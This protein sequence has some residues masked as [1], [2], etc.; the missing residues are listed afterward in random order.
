ML[1]KQPC[2][3]PRIEDKNILAANLNSPTIHLYEV[4]YNPQSYDVLFQSQAQITQWLSALFEHEFCLNGKKCVIESTSLNNGFLILNL[5]EDKFQWLSSDTVASASFHPRIY[6]SKFKHSDAEINDNNK[7]KNDNP[8][9]FSFTEDHYISSL[10][11]LPIVT[12]ST[13][14]QKHHLKYSHVTKK[15]T[16]IVIVK[17][18]LKLVA[19]VTNI[20]DKNLCK[21]LNIPVGIA[22]RKKMMFELFK[23]SFG[24]EILLLLMTPPNQDE[25]QFYCPYKYNLKSY[26]CHTEEEFLY[27]FKRH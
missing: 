17:E 24:H 22:N 7:T 8:L 3:R 16:C 10:Q 13:F 18:F 5:T 19:S 26:S 9:W 21:K 1:L 25:F 2:T 6:L 15:E 4:L 23:Q 12:L 11:L 14:L 27:I 20:S